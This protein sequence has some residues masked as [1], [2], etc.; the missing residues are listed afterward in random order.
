MRSGPC[1]LLSLPS[2]W[3][4]RCRLQ[5]VGRELCV[6]HDQSPVLPHWGQ[7]PDGRL[8]VGVGP[9]VAGNRCALRTLR[10]PR[11]VLGGHG[12]PKGNGGIA[13]IPDQRRRR[14]RCGCSSRAMVYSGKSLVGRSRWGRNGDLPDSR[15]VL[16]CPLRS[17]WLYLRRA[18]PV[19][20]RALRCTRMY[21]PA[22]LAQRAERSV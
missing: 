11:V 12:G 6:H 16:A 14:N 20:V 21:F 19:Q 17:D 4:C 18:P 1:V 22:H 13:G 10:S 8:L 9:I 15:A 3:V 7:R 2:G 5:D